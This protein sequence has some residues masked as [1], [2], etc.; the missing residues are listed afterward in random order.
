[1]IREGENSARSDDLI[2]LLLSARKSLR[3]AKDFSSSDAIRSGL[4]KLGVHIE[5]Q[6]SETIW[7]YSDTEGE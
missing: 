4:R 5:D 7:W 1:M 2:R 6:G 3:T